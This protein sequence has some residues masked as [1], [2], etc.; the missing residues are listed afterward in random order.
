MR[1]ARFAILEK[2][3][4]A[5]IE[6][7]ELGPSNFLADESLDGLHMAGIFGD[8]QCERIASRLHATSAPDA[9][10]VILGM[11]RDI[12]VDDMADI[13]DVQAASGNIRGDQHF[14]PPI[15]KAAQS[16]LAFALRSVGMKDSDGVVV[17]FEQMGD[18]VGA[19]FGAAKDDDRV[20]VDAFEQ[21]EEQWPKRAPLGWDVNDPLPAARGAV[22]LLSD[23]FPATSGEIVHVDGGAHAI[24]A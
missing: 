6:V 14:V 24:G 4:V 13:G 22:A 18:A 23:W 3:G 12:V 11:L 8:H 19:V 1:A 2:G 5:I 10:N 21:F 17:A 15:T 16:L 7:F 20:V 9:V